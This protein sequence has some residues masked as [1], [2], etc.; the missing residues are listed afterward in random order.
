M[1]AEL[2][3]RYLWLIVSG[4][5]HC[6]AQPADVKPQSLLVA[7]WK[8][9]KKEYLDWLLRDEAAQGLM[10][11][12]A[13]SSQWLHVTSVKIKGDVG[14]VESYVYDQSTTDQCALPL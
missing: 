5:E 10:K 7:E 12:A 8:L 4:R 2:Q 9:E 13:E 3:S 1:Q 14:S 6:P 11:G